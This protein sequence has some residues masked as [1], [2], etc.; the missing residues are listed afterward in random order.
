MA[1]SAR[2]VTMNEA[3]ARAY[4]WA[5]QTTGRSLAETN[6]RLLAV[7][8]RDN[9]H[10]H[11]VEKIAALEST[12]LFRMRAVDAHRERI[13]ALEDIERRWKNGEAYLGA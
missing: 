1:H 11:L 7:F 3:Q 5:N 4:A 10:H 13:A 9:D 2:E 12:V 6:A 8:I